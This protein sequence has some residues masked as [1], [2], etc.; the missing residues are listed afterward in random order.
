[1]A[2]H[3]RQQQ[4]NVDGVGTWVNGKKVSDST[5][6]TGIDFDASGNGSV[7]LDDG[8][9]LNYCGDDQ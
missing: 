2:K 1:M 8:T 4:I 5:V 6:I 3:G 7:S 9:T